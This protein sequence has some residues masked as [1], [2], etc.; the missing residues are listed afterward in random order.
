MSIVRE[1]I[2]PK[3]PRLDAPRTFN[4]PYSIGVKCDGLIFLSGMTAID[5]DS[6]ERK[7]G[8]TASETRDILAAMAEVLAD[9]GASLANVLKVNVFLHSLLEAESFNTAYRGFFS[10]LPP[11]RNVSGVVL[12][13]GMKVA[14]EC[15]A[16]AEGPDG[17]AR[18]RS[19]IAPRNPLLN[20]SRRHNRPHSPGIRI[21]DLIFV[22]GMVPLDPATG[23][24]RL[25]PTS[26]QIAL[27]LSNMA[28]L[29]ESAESSLDRVIKLNVSMANMLECDTFYRIMPTFFPRDPPACTVVGMQLSG[30]HGVEI[31][32]VAA[33]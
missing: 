29:L 17:P 24:S 15:I 32:C 1:L 12:A 21:G 28:H 19:P 20:N 25:G 7:H 14:I 22:S 11:A 30:G 33:A 10:D 31:E 8:T 6:G 23:E 5:R 2:Q 3:N 4:L 18:R 26:E 13:S 16:L 9:A 27:V